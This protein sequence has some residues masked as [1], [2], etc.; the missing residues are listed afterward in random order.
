MFAEDVITEESPVEEASLQ[1]MPKMMSFGELLEAGRQDK[2][3]AQ[4][5]CDPRALKNGHLG[6]MAWVW[7]GI[8]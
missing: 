2:N 3:Q 5:Q 6:K 7:N 8:G 4:G 1:R